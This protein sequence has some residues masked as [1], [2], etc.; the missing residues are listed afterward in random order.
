[1]KFQVVRFFGTVNRDLYLIQ[2][3]NCHSVIDNGLYFHLFKT[4]DEFMNYLFIVNHAQIN[5]LLQ[6]WPE[7][8]SIV[9]MHS[10]GGIFHKQNIAT[11]FQSAATRFD[12]MLQQAS[13]S[14]I[15]FWTQFAPVLFSNDKH[16]ICLFTN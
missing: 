10:M 2:I 7:S 1:M 8:I 13:L 15:I 12:F 16:N 5:N 3:Y 14:Q 9:I 6:S 4:K 11:A